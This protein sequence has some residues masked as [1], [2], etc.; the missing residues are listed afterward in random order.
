MGLFCRMSVKSS[1]QNEQMKTL[2]SP[3]TV[4]PFL[5][6]ITALQWVSK[7]EVAVCVDQ[8]QNLWT[9]YFFLRPGS[10][11]WTIWHLNQALHQ[12][13]KNSKT[14]TQ[15]PSR[16]KWN[17][18]AVWRTPQD[19]GGK[20]CF[21]PIVWMWEEGRVLFHYISPFSEACIQFVSWGGRTSGQMCEE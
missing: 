8:R 21:V 18:T 6:H 17:V 16:C 20:C 11:L 4:L 19:L 13:N 2:V 7:L 12:G 1:L 9:F 14:A 15:R 5:N 3:A 10:F